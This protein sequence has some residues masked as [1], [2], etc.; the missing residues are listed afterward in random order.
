MRESFKG[1]QRAVCVVALGALLPL[2]EAAAQNLPLNAT[3]RGP[4]GVYGV[5]AIDSCNTQS[6]TQEAFDDCVAADIAADLSNPE[7]AGISAEI[8]WT[9]LLLRALN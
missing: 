4:Q 2:C 7:V 8:R 6:A 9:Y 5:I 1:F 3:F